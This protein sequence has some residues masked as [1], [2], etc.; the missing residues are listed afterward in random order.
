MP[1]SEVYN[2]DC[3]IGMAR[4]PDKFFD[5][6][7][8]DPPY[9]RN[10]DG[11]IDRGKFVKQRNGSRLYVAGNYKKKNWDNEP[12][13]PEYF[14][15]LFR[16]SKHQIIFG[17]NYWP[18]QFPGSGRIIW[19]KCNDGSDQSGAE[20]AFNS[21]NDRVEVF[22]YMWRGMF[23]GKSIEAGHIQQGNKRLNEKRIHPTQ[24][25]AALY[26]WILSKYATAGNNILDTHM[27]SQSSRIACFSMGFDYWGWEIDED[28]LRDG[29]KRFKELTA[30]QK[31]F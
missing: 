26:N 6:A 8:V 5:L 14:K 19:D 13:S 16:V 21:L 25:P 23:Q 17:C 9:G 22:R 3:M 18:L 27:G 28:Y 1:I 29:N 24:K 30:Q 2:E 20:I 11:G 7:I 10:E 15:E 31:M 4:F 12:A